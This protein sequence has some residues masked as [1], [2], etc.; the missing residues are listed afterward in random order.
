[1]IEAYIFAGIFII[2][3]VCGILISILFFYYYRKN[4]LEQKSLLEK[5][6][7]EL[8]CSLVKEQ[9]LRNQIEQNLQLRINELSD[10]KKN[11]KDVFEAISKESLL[12]NSLM[13]NQSFKQRSEEHTSELQSH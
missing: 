4:L 1:M 7:L 2:G 3:F 5:N 13:L 10:I 8:S 9:T 6:N 12:N 11:M